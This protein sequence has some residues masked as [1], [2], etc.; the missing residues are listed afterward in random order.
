MDVALQLLDLESEPGDQCIRMRVHRLG[1]G[2]NG[3][4][5]TSGC[6][7]GEDHRMPLARSS[8]S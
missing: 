3:F 1:A 6:T 4:R 8:G 5:F 2:G 7:L